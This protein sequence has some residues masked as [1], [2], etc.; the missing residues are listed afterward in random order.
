MPETSARNYPRSL[1][2]DPLRR[3]AAKRY[4]WAVGVLLACSLVAISA[5]GMYM[6]LEI[7]E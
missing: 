3:S 1:P 6:I 4:R 5:S 7:E 2:F